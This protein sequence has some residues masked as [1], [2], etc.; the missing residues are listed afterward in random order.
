MK[1]EKKYKYLPSERE[2][3]IRSSEDEFEREVWD[4]STN[5]PHWIKKLNPIAEAWERKPKEEPDG[6]GVKYTLPK[7]AI[8]FR[9]PMKQSERTEKQKASLEKARETKLEKQ[10]EIKQMTSPIQ[11]RAVRKITLGLVP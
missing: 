7:K 8:S 2:I 4:I 3:I 1:S 11:G 5:S 6:G 9:R 10:R